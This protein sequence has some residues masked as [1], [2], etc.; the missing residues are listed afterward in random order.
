MLASTANAT[1]GRDSTP[2]SLGSGMNIGVAGSARAS[3]PVNNL[4]L[5][6]VRVVTGTAG[7]LILLETWSGAAVTMLVDA[8]IT[9][10]HTPGL[11]H[12]SPLHEAASPRVVSSCG[13][14]VPVALALGERWPPA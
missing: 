3:P 1:L 10:P 2:W 6:G 7:P 5:P 4:A 8:A 12:G 9:S 14:D 13:L 11:I